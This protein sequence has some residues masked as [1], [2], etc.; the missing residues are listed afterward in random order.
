MTLESGYLVVF[1]PGNAGWVTVLKKYLSGDLFVP[2][3]GDVNAVPGVVSPLLIS[4]VFLQVSLF[5]PSHGSS[6]A[7]LASWNNLFISGK[8]VVK[9]KERPFT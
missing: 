7:S 5:L 2:I 9:L 6:P 1:T 4:E 3:Q 8:F